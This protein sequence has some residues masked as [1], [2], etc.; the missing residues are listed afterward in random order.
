MSDANKAVVSSLFEAIGSGNLDAID[1][2]VADNFVEHEELPG[3][4]PDREG[5]KALFG[6]LRT[7]FPD[8]SFVPQMMIA[9]GDLVSVFVVFSG[10]NQGEFMG[11][12]ATGRS[13]TVNVTDW[14]R[15]RDGKVVEHW[16]VM[17]MASMMQQLGVGH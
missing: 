13:V 6:M 12:P 11:M 8:F 16:G 2:I 1:T 15:V 4:T 9:E 7:A 5:V 3:L 17:D 10:T 14:M